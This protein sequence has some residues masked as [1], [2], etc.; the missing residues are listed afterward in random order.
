MHLLP[1]CTILRYI[2]IH[3]VI[4]QKFTIF[5]KEGLLVTTLLPK[6]QRSN[7]QEIQPDRTGTATTLGL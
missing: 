7:M 3:F 4:Q 1:V 2:V 6:Q 5:L